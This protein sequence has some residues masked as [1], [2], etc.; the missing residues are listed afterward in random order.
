MTTIRRPFRFGGVL[1]SWRGG[2][3]AGAAASRFCRALSV[4]PLLAQCPE[5]P[6]R[7]GEARR[8]V[9]AASKRR[10]EPRRSRQGDRPRHSNSDATRHLSA[11]GGPRIPART[12]GNPPPC[13]RRLGDL[14]SGRH[15]RDS[16]LWNLATLPA[17]AR[18]MLGHRP[19]PGSRG[20]EGGS[21]TTRATPRGR[22]RRQTRARRVPPPAAPARC[23]ELICPLPRKRRVREAGYPSIIQR[24][25]Y[26]SA[27][28]CAVSLLTA[29]LPWPPSV[30]SK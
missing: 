24:Y 25:A 28:T 22:V 17:R 23:F 20:L 15:P 6:P 5:R 21:R 16:G 29:P 2:K 1:T 19:L 30:F 10:P 8:G 27:V 12:I 7:D 18:R 3:A 11:P 9:T 4:A 13:T 14:G 26:W